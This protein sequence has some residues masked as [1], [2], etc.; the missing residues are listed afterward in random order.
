MRTAPKISQARVR[1]RPSVT[2]PPD[3]TVANVIGPVYSRDFSYLNIVDG[4][5]ADSDWRLADRDGAGWLS[6]KPS[7]IRH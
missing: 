1:A 7:A 6:V 5:S 3:S 4:G 2:A